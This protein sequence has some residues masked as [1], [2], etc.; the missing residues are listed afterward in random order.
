MLKTAASA[1]NISAQENLGLI[2]SS[3]QDVPLNAP[4]A[5]K[6]LKLAASQGR[7]EAQELL[8]NLPRTV[9][10]YKGAVY[11]FWPPPDNS[12]DSDND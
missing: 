1:G 8:D 10:S 7:A 11:I 2:Y 9:C 12:D 3:N 5:A 6:W 4:E